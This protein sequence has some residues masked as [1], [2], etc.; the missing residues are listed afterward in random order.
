M[1][2]LSYCPDCGCKMFSGACTN[3][4]EEIYIE[5][6]YYDLCEDPPELIKRKADEQRQAIKEKQR[7]Y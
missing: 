7:E 5:D 2:G 4:H 1:S 3:C 6:Q